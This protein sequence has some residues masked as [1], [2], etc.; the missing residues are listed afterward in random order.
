MVKLYRHTFDW[1]HL[2]CYD[3]I[4]PGLTQFVKQ[5]YDA[6]LRNN[7]VTWDISGLE[8]LLEELGSIKDSKVLRT[9]SP[10]YTSKK[11]SFKFCILWKTACS[12]VLLSSHGIITCKYVSEYDKRSLVRYCLV[13]NDNQ[14]PYTGDKGHGQDTMQLN[15][16]VNDPLDNPSVLWV[17]I[18]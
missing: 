4:D 6:E 3:L 7:Y 5:R 8:S 18:T 2:F 12:S 17:N 11:S 14:G 9:F 10:C 16:T 13:C 1:K 15:L